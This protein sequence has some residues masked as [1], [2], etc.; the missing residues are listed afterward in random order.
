MKNFL[1][2][3]ISPLLV[4]L[5]P[6]I[7]LY[8]YNR[9]ML[10]LHQLVFPI[11]FAF[12][13]VVLFFVIWKILF[14]DN[15]K[16]SL[17]TTG[18]LIIFWNYELFYR[19]LTYFI[20]L[21]HWHI[22]PLCLFIYAHL[23]YLVSIKSK[24]NLKI[25]NKVI[26]VMF[27]FLIGFNL[28]IIIS[29][30]VGKYK[31][32]L[33]ELEHCVAEN[34]EEIE[35]SAFP[36]IYLLIF[37]EYANLDTIKEEWGYDNY[38]F[39]QFLREKGFYLAENSKVRY[40]ETIKTMP[41]LLNIEYYYG[42]DMESLCLLYLN[43]Y[44]FKFF[45]NKGYKILFL[46]GYLYHQPYLQGTIPPYVHTY[47]TEKKVYED[48]NFFQLDSFNMLL[49]T[50]SLLYPFDFLLK[51]D[52]THLLY[53]DGTLFF[54][55]Y[56]KYHVHLEDSPKLVFAHIMCPH[57]PYVFDREGNLTN[58]KTHYWQFE[59]YSKGELKEM[60][61]E[62]YIYVTNE[63]KN[64]IKKIQTSNNDA[65]LIIQS[66]HGS[67]PNST[68]IE[69]ELHAFKVLNAIYFPDKDYYNLYDSISPVNT[70]RIMLNQ[71]FGMNYEMLEDY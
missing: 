56:L 46:D 32:S 43:N 25:V 7:F 20:N 37:D 24:I 8:T 48:L 2:Y 28:S 6:V 15:L 59:D 67:R 41:E 4:S 53:Y 50:R 30:E 63:I 26:L 21:K 31:E 19:G 61:L 39:A 58:N 23:V 42:K 12:L 29:E 66:D 34:E 18:F 68:G 13:M 3:L 47:L 22:L 27:S 71:Y 36:D 10:S 64:I 51:I 54:F 16:A 35:S 70:L 69:D 33:K 11:S 49:F 14:K 52:N 45:Y 44:L 17:S 40:S 1:Y 60:Y 5:Y 62:Q 38:D 65:I 9:E 57:M 55:N